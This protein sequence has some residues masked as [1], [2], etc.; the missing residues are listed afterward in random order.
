MSDTKWRTCRQAKV[1]CGGCGKIGSCTVSPDGTAFKCWRD[2]GRVI[3][4]APKPIHQSGNGQAHRPKPTRPKTPDAKTGRTYPTIAAT[5]EAAAVAIGGEL[6]KTWGYHNADGTPF[7]SVGRINLPDGS[8]QFRPAHEA[9][10]GAKLG[11]PPGSWPLLCLPDLAGQKLVIVCEGEKAADAARAIGLPATTSAHGSGSADKSDWTP[12][13]GLHAI[14]LPDNDL[15]GEKYVRDVAKILARLDPPCRCKI[16]NLPGLGDGE[17]I[18]EFLERGGTADDIGKLADA[19]PWIDAAD[20]N[21]GPVLTCLAD[22]ESR[23]V[24]WLWAGRVPLGRITLLVGRP[25]EGKSFLTTD[26]TARVTT[27]SP[28]PDGSPCPKGSVILVSAEDDPADTIRPRLDAHRADCR[29]VHLLSAVRWFDD[30]AKAHERFFTLAD[31]AALEA[32]LQAHRDCR[33]IVVD[34]IGSFLGGDTDSHRDNEVRGIL[35]PVAKMAE[36]YGPAVLVVAHSRKATAT[37]ADDLAIGSRAFT[38]IARAVWHLSRDRTPDAQAIEAMSGKKSPR[39]LLLPGK[40]NLGPEGDGLAF[41]IAGDP[42]A[43]EWEREPVRMS[44]DEALAQENGLDDSR[45]GPEPEAR[46]QA[47]QWLS[48]LLAG[49]A[50]HT[51]KVEAEAKA[52]G[53]SWRTIRRAGDVL[54]VIRE[55]CPYSGAWQWR[56]PKGP[57]SLGQVPLSTNNLDNLDNLPISTENSGILTGEN[58]NLSTCPRSNELD[59]LDGDGQEKGAE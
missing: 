46:R 7:A 18:V 22:V 34:P 8:K 50:L 48:D 37:F 52:A 21:G 38:G 42:P 51:V 41:I 27:G 36:R 29:R 32:A 24:S 53:I 33:L 20:L 54:G 19:T 9:K 1:E 16:V 56:L 44:A 25:G 47:E 39:R 3:Q 31:L 57:Q 23:A 15:P 6:V 49:G 5:L 28:F 13:A 35:A 11:D 4:T 40:N 58:V 26:I 59:N 12:L 45:P 2:G 43:I 55:R 30:N 14:L 17:D 10:N